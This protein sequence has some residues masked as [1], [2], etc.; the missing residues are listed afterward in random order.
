MLARPCA[1]R[2]GVSKGERARLRRLPRLWCAIG[3]CCSWPCRVPPPRRPAVRPFIQASAGGTESIDFLAAGCSTPP[4]C[5]RVWR[6]RPTEIATASAT[7]VIPRDGDSLSH[8]G[9]FQDHDGVF[10]ALRRVDPCL[11]E[12]GRR[13]TLFAQGTVAD[14][15]VAHAVVILVVAACRQRAGRLTGSRR[16]LKAL[17]RRPLPT[18]HSRNRGDGPATLNALAVDASVVDEPPGRRLA[19]SDALRTELVKAMANV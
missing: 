4:T 1:R 6:T 11:E 15:L 18:S 19:I 13:A 17:K 3:F 10:D 14:S 5:A 7:P 2:R 12:G 16:Q 8:A 9:I